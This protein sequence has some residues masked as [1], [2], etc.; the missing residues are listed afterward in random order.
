MALEVRVFDEV[1]DVDP[2]VMWG[3]TFRQLIAAAVM[4][5]A[6]A[7]VSWQA[8]SSGNVEHAPSAIVATCFPVVLW[9]WTR[10]AGL[11]LERWLPHVVRA[12]FSSP[13]LLY[14]DDKI[15]AHQLGKRRPHVTQAVRKE[16]R[17]GEAG[18]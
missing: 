16:K 5:A 4:V 8:V 18:R 14:V 11:R 7:F 1:T 3:L 6:S 12:I 10:P 9:A 17:Q 15:W 13:K 2:K